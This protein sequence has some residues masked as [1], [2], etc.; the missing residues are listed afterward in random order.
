MTTFAQ[1]C[2]SALVLTLVAAG[3][4]LAVTA[5]ERAACTPDVFRLCSSEIP[6]VERIVGCMRRER[7]KLSPA[8]AKVFSSDVPR[9]ASRSVMEPDEIQVMVR[10]IISQQPGNR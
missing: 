9:T 4:T 7:A 1:K 2:L 3:P 10:E 8:C 6:S 5:E